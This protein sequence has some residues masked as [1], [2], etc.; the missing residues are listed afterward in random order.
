MRKDRQGFALRWGLGTLLA[1]VAAI[2]IL[3]IGDNIII[4]PPPS[5]IYAPQSIAWMLD[6][7]WWAYSGVGIGLIAAVASIRASNQQSISF[8]IIAAATIVTPL[9]LAAVALH[10]AGELG[11]QN[12]LGLGFAYVAFYLLPAFM[13][14]IFAML[15]GNL[16]VSTIEHTFSRKS[17]VD[18]MPEELRRQHEA[19]QQRHK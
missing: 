10:D 7:P 19:A 6:L 13:P 18:L 16:I 14:A 17:L 1:V 4:L 15:I 11:L 5:R 8:A 9:I 12:Y 2:I 3:K